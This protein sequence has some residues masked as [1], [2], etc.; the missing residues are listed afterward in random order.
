MGVISSW[1]ATTIV[2]VLAVILVIVMLFGWTMD[3]FSNY[4]AQKLSQ[5]HKTQMIVYAILVTIGF[6]FIALAIIAA[7]L[8]YIR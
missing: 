2:A 7:V 3:K 4:F 6:Y 1:S 8:R 5:D